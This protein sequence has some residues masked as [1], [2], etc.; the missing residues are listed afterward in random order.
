MFARKHQLNSS[1]R[2]RLSVVSAFAC[3]GV[4]VSLSAWPGLSGE[5]S[6]RS[7][8]AVDFAASTRPVRTAYRQLSQ[9]APWRSARV[10]SAVRTGLHLGDGRLLVYAPFMDRAVGSVVRLPGDLELSLNLLHYEAALGVALLQ[11]DGGERRLS[12]RI[13]WERGFEYTDTGAQLAIRGYRDGRLTRRT[14]FSSGMRSGVLNAGKPRSLKTSEYS[15][16]RDHLAAPGLNREL[17]LLQFHDGGP[18][19]AP[20]DT[21]Y[22]AAGQIVGIVVRYSA[23]EES[24]LALPAA[25]LQSYVGLV[26]RVK[27][28]ANRSLVITPGVQLSDPGG[29]AARRHYGLADSDSGPRLVSRVAVT[30]LRANERLLRGDLILEWNGKRPDAAGRLTDSRYGSLPLAALAGLAA[31]RLQPPGTTVRLEVLRERERRRIQIQLR[32]GDATGAVVPADFPRPAYLIAG[33]LAF[34]ELS[35][36]YLAERERDGA[37]AA[38]RLDYLATTVGVSGPERTRYVV[39]ERVLPLPEPENQALREDLRTDRPLLLQSLNGTAVRNLR[40][41]RALIRTALQ[42]KRDLVFNLEEGHLIVL[43]GKDGG[44]A[45]QA[46]NRAVRARHGIAFLEGGLAAGPGSNRGH[47][48]GAGK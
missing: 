16:D 6:A 44:A 41:L 23:K 24:G 20:G 46:L 3:S 21:V 30:R 14:A 18:G 42:D 35:E 27:P 33:G 45:L 2:R 29:A 1:L 10:E 4:L 9:R 39:L 22:T 47:S 31:G 11:I 36:A 43:P 25:L 5:V 38:P 13:R 40:H 8:S 26:D 17:P 37:T 32:A 28:E 19:I 12:G 7:S 48:A 15:A 34:V